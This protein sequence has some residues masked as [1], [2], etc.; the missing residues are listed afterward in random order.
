MAIPNCQHVVAQLSQQYPQEW[1][2]AHNPSGGGPHTEAFIRRLA[3]VLHSTVDARFGLNGKRGNPNDISDDALNFRGVGPGHDP[4]N[5]NAP[6]TVIDCIGG[7]GG[8]NPTPAWQ[9]FDTLPGPGAWVQPVPVDGSVGGGVTS[10]TPRPPSP[11]PDLRP[12]LDALA[13]LDARVTGLALEVS[14]VKARL[15]TTER[16]AATAAFEALNAA[17]RASEIKTLLDARPVAP[18]YEGRLFGQ[19]ITLTPKG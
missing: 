6:V 1:R 16:D 10:P 11:A 5:G 7:A 12:V 2:D 8:P 9:V 19:R 13:A 3:W 15:F 18:V 4:T 14:D 17:T